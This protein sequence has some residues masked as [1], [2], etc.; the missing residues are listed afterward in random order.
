MVCTS[1]VGRPNVSS[2]HFYIYISTSRAYQLLYAV[3]VNFK[4]K[5]IFH[6]SLNPDY[7]EANRK[8][9]VIIGGESDL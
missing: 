3:Y 9:V 7:Q 1:S 8:C 4:R 6:I 2:L 5:K